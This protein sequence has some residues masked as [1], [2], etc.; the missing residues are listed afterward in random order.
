[1]TQRKPGRPRGSKGEPTRVIQA[2]VLEVHVEPFSAVCQRLGLT[3]SMVLRMFVQEVVQRDKL[4]LEWL[5]AD[6]IPSLEITVRQGREAEQ[7]LA[8]LRKELED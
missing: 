3:T 2:R 7:T 8:A 5:P 1:M 4:P 6:F